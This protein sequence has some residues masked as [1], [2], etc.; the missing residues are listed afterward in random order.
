MNIHVIRPFTLL[1]VLVL[2]SPL[3]HRAA[4]LQE[5]ATL[6]NSL[7]SQT[8]EK[9]NLPGLGIGVSVDGQ[10]VLL[11]GLGFSHLDTRSPVD[12]E[13]SLFRIGSISKPLTAA[14]LARLHEA[15]RI[16]LQ[17]PVQTFVP[18]YPK[19]EWDIT[20]LQLAGHLGGIR[21]YQGR[22]FASNQAYPTVK[23]SL[24]IFMQDPLLHPPGSKY[25]YSSYGWTLI[26]AVMEGASGEPFLAYMKK[27]VFEPLEMRHTFP[28]LKADASLNRVGFYRQVLGINLPAE[29][30]DNSYKWAGGGVLST[31]SDLLTFGN[32]HLDTNYLSAATLRRWTTP[33][34]TSD[35]KPTRYGIGWQ[36]GRDKAGRSWFGH[37]GGSVGGTSML[38]IYP[39][40]RIVVVTLTNVRPAKLNNLAFRMAEPF[41]TA[42]VEPKPK[43]KTSSER[44]KEILK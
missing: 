31:V 13:R 34:R 19:K 26:S 15:G 35:G 17:A 27:E 12:P 38:L 32:A 36:V 18:D 43:E 22:E 44:P 7:A 8:L 41:L 33:Q 11:A 3:T 6:A 37:S 16:D 24:E 4:D 40:E 14:G 42:R 9:S 1:L 10:T 25:H 20:T 5:S 23:A 39:G 2:A 30:V 21:H 28:D 29:D